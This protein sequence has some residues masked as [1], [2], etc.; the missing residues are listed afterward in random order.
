MTEG[1]WEAGRMWEKGEGGSDGEKI[2]D[3][4]GRWR[5]REKEG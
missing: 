1:G 4:G 3:E 5:K 2:R